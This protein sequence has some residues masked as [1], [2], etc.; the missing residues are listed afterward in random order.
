LKAGRA[1]QYGTVDN[2]GIV[3]E[4]AQIHAGRDSIKAI[5][6]LQVHLGKVVYGMQH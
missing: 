6:E 5:L 3:I 4:F 2:A 1:G